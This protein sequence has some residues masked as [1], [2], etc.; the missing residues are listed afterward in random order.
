MKIDLRGEELLLLPEKCIYWPKQSLLILS[1]L[2]LG[3]AG[4]FRKNGI[5][6][7]LKV[8]VGD[9]E[10]IDNLILNYQPI[11]I[12]FLG[13]LF[14]S[15][16]NSEWWNFISWIQKHRQIRFTLVKGNHDIIP[17]ILFEE[18]NIGVVN[19]L[20]LGPFNFTHIREEKANFY[21]LSGHIH[22]GVRL[23]G[24]GKQA[25]TLPCFHFSTSYGILPAFGNFTG[26]AKI[27]PAKNDRIFVVT[28]RSVMD[29]GKS[30][31]Q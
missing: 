2:H 17:E 3:K 6:I 5:P 20:D 4:H 10:K 28:D 18:A 29:V 31:N 7:P 30:I 13:D 11:H 1:D 21:N 27:K 19:S 12:L 22:P 9:L 15:D 14:H 23:Y 26:I 16:L 8:H 25:V 24:M